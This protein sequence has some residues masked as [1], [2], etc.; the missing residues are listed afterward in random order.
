MNF[1][2]LTKCFTGKPMNGKRRIVKPWRFSSAVQ[3]DEYFIRNLR[4]DVMKRESR[5]QAN[6]SVG[7][8]AATVNRSGFEIGCLPGI[9]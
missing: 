2:A 3:G 9:R 8:L 1:N 4:C 5:N 7:I 6:D